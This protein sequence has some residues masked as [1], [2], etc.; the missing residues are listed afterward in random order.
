MTELIIIL[1]LCQVLERVLQ[2]SELLGIRSIRLM[3]LCVAKIWTLIELPL[4]NEVVPFLL[5]RRSFHI[6]KLLAII[7]VNCKLFVEALGRHTHLELRRAE[8]I[9][10]GPSRRNM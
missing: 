9:L 8:H 5:I 3:E 6:L 7:I 4:P 1:S 2:V 10:G